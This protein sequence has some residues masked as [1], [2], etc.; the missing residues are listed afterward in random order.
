MI[1]VVLGVPVNRT[2]H[3]YQYALYRITKL[4]E[5]YRHHIFPELL[6]SLIVFQ[7]RCVSCKLNYE[8]YQSCQS[9]Q[10]LLQ[11]KVTAPPYIVLNY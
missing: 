1:K 10:E 3:L 2:H 6:V 5:L 8:I 4:V 7:V 9:C 11:A